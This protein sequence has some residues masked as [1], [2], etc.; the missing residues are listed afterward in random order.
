[1]STFPR[2]GVE[3]IQEITPAAP[4]VLSSTLNPCVIGPCF[5]I[6]KAKSPTGDLNPIAVVSTPA[7][8]VAASAVGEQV[9]AADKILALTIDGGDLIVVQLPAVATGS[10]INANIVP[11]AIMAKTGGA[12]SVKLVD[13]KFVFTAK[14]KGDASKLKF[15]SLTTLIDNSAP[16]FSESS[17]MA[18]DDLGIASA[19]LDTDVSGQGSYANSVYTVPYEKLPVDTFHPA[20]T[21]M[22]FQAANLDL[23]RY[24]PGSLKKLSETSAVNWTSYIGGATKLNNVAVA[25]F[26]LNLA[27]ST[28]YAKNGVGSTTARVFTAGADASLVLPLTKYLASNSSFYPDASGQHYLSVTAKGAQDYLMDQS[29]SLG[30][31][32]GAA[33]N[34][35]H[36]TFVP[37]ASAETLTWPSATELV[38]TYK[39]KF[40]NSGAP[41]TYKNLVDLI[42]ASASTWAPK[43]QT[44]SLVYPVASADFP[45]DPSTST[46][47]LGE[48]TFYLS[49]GQDPVPFNV[50]GT[51]SAVVVGSMPFTN[52]SCAAVAGKN[53]AISVNGGP[54][55]NVE[56]AATAAATLT[57]INTCVALGNVTSGAA[58]LA[59]ASLSL[60]PKYGNEGTAHVLR[61]TAQITASAFNHDCSIKVGGDPEVVEALL[62]GFATK[63]ETLADGGSGAVTG[64]IESGADFNQLAATSL[65]AA[66]KPGSV[67]LKLNSVTTKAH[68][69]SATDCT[70][71]HGSMTL[72]LSHSLCIGDG[73]LLGAPFS[74]TFT[75]DAT[76][77]GTTAG[78]L[79]DALAAKAAGSGF[80]GDF[81]GV[82]VR[83]V[84]DSSSP[85]RIV[86]FDKTETG[87]M[88]LVSSGTTLA[89]RQAFEGTGGSNTGCFDTAVTTQVQTVTITDNPDK[90][91][92]ADASIATKNYI[93][94]VGWSILSSGGMSLTKVNYASGVMDYVLD[95][96][97]TNAAGT[98][99][100]SITYTR[101][102]VSL[103]S[104]DIVD[105][106]S[107]IW[108]GQ[109]TKVVPG[110]RLWDKGAVVATVI[111][112]EN[113][114]PAG[115]TGS[116]G[117]GCVLTLNNEALA[118]NGKL[119]NWYVTAE[120]LSAGS[121][122]I[123]PEIVFDDLAQTAVIKPNVNIGVNGVPKSGSSAIYAE[124]KALRLDV[125]D[126]ATIPGLLVMSSAD[127][128]AKQ[129]GPID[130]SNPLAFALYL[131][132]LNA[133]DINL[134]AIGVSAVTSRAPHGTVEAYLDAFDYLKKHEVYSLAALTDDSTVHQLLNGHVRA[135]SAPEQKKER[136]GFICPALPTE[137]AAQVV[138][139]GLVAPPEDK[140]GG[141]YEFTFD[142]SAVVTAALDG[143][144]D[145]NGQTID[146]G[147]NSTF[148]A[149]KGIFLTRAGDAYRYLVTKC[150]SDHVV[151]CQVSKTFDGGKGPG[152]F[153]N[154]DSFYVASGAALAS[155]T[156]SEE[157]SVSIRGASI[158]TSSTAGKLAQCETLADIAG[159]TAG[160]QNRRL[161]LLQPENIGV[162][163]GGLDLKV[164]GFYAGAMIAAMVGEYNSSQPFTNLPM[165]GITAV[166]GSNDKFTED[167]MATA[168]SGG[169]YWLL[170][171]TVGAPIVSRHQL[172]TDMTSVK[173]RELSITKAIDKVSKQLRVAVKR[174]IG[175]N[176]ITDGLLSQ[177][178]LVI[179]GTIKATIG[180]DVAD[181]T[182]EGI[183]RNADNPDQIDIIV[184][185]TPLY[186]ANKITIRV[187]I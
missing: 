23:Y 53:L 45:I 24:T 90:A 8:M 64:T 129:I 107:T 68:F 163:F 111:K 15:Y 69:A 114:N 85:L 19:Q 134:S 92:P 93:A 96:N 132:F 36:V 121:S 1:M 113:H 159:G 160:Y 166:Y 95:G 117:D 141:V 137:R 83:N 27:K 3:V 139:S 104:T 170:Q 10:L 149:N 50:T 183:E 175:R 187:V 101:G 152:T 48:L 46:N 59:D 171:D 79:F 125:T 153:G 106:T 61:L 127:D 40:L 14:T 145:A 29:K 123:Q 94:P 116:W 78:N 42:T 135:M 60:A 138:A 158:N 169:V 151:E 180:V 103:V 30:A 57:A 44:L 62:A 12:L 140:G 143:K 181:A 7:R 99:T 52:A 28:L 126:K 26:P 70:S 97:L 164:P 100:R 172:T 133:P 176:N 33:G 174:F 47:E 136:I 56:V 67:S 186:P 66:L 178:G 110:D 77:I 112:V 82:D 51:S 115:K 37:S 184:T 9:S 148:M 65:M 157:C 71:A 156:A 73:A 98:F 128:V 16:G 108:T 118:K 179:T 87:K 177:I 74:V 17:V 39:S 58:V 84:S 142:D 76:T 122:R 165:V 150:V 185:L 72:K 13:N 4:S 154:D 25:G 182:L 31:Y 144:K 38:I 109:S 130:P 120:N 162:Q 18:Y 131:G 32:A 75:V 81:V 49:G 54:T 55:V 167:Q 2:P 34:D 5:A 41:T 168:A 86:L 63:T 146:A 22:V 124:Y 88:Q 89:F 21:E 105:Y 173:T 161:V 20:A 119:D 35:L 11:D 43:F 147:V 80:A 155:F 91:L 6:V 102:A